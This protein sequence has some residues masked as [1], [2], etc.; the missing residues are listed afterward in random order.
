MHPP[1]EKLLSLLCKENDVGRMCKHL[2]TISHCSRSVSSTHGL[3]KIAVLT[4]CVECMTGAGYSSWDF[5]GLLDSRIERAI[6][7]CYYHPKWGGQVNRWN[8]LCWWSVS[9]L[10]RCSRTP[11]DDKH[12]PDMVWKCHKWPCHERDLTR[13]FVGGRFSKAHEPLANDH[14]GFFALLSSG[15]GPLLGYRKG[16]DAIQHWQN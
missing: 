9:D 13:T 16:E 11:D 14:V 2:R 10:D 6:S 5:C 8:S 4:S 12:M 15:H 1:R 3:P 7:Q